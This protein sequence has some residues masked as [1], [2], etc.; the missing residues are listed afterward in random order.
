MKES[1]N[2]KTILFLLVGILGSIVIFGVGTYTAG[3]AMRHR[4]KLF[5]IIVIIYILCKNI[6][7][8]EELSSCNVGKK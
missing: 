1:T 8:K 4:H 6:N 3:A 2:K 5:Y 7:N